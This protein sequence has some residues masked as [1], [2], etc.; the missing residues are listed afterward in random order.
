MWSKISILLTV[1]LSLWLASYGQKKIEG[2]LQ[3]ADSIK[4][5]IIS[6]HPDSFPIISI[7]FR[8][9]KPTGEPIWGLAKRNFSIWEDKK[10]CEILS[11]DQISQNKSINIGIVI[12]HS[13]SM[14]EDESQ[15]VDK[16][17]DPLSIYDIQTGE[18]D[19]PD[20]Y[21]SPLD[22]AK[23]TTKEFVQSFNDRKDLISIVGFSTTVDYIL[24]LTNN[25]FRIDSTINYLQ[26]EGR[27]ALYDAMIRG[28]REI[29]NKAGVNVLV[30][31][32]DG[33]DNESSF[34]DE[35]VIKEAVASDIP[36]FIIGLGNVNKK[37]LQKIA[38]GSNGRFVY[39]QTAKSFGEIYSKISKD[40][41]SFY[42]LTYES[43][44]L[45]STKIKRDV[46]IN[47]ISNSGKTDSLRYELNL[48]TEIILYLQA[49]E[50]KRDYIMSGMIISAIAI[51]TLSIV[52]VKRKRK[53]KKKA[54]TI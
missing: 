42:D 11:V 25:K 43:P 28:L 1:S 22:N 33:N 19:L 21:V 24:P 18:V 51:S 23:T 35:D 41:Q 52:I 10:N 17:G 40:I 12:D 14:L 5:T 46:K 20:G 34:K 3:S 9:F 15:L 54:V 44:N 30:T 45:S 53:K 48:P 29:K 4:Y 38:D 27:T 6:V 36:I 50:K 7:I 2:K 8:A 13:G 49:K 39:T 32:T 37:A 31:L 47:F 16:W 26:S